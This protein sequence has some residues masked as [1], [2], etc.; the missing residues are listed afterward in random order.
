MTSHRAAANPAR[1]QPD[2]QLGPEEAGVRQNGRL[3]ITGDH[4]RPQ[5]GVLL[6]RFRPG[7][8]PRGAHRGEHDGEDGGRVV[9][10]GDFVF[11]PRPERVFTKEG[12]FPPAQ[13]VCIF[14][15]LLTQV[16]ILIDKVIDLKEVK[17]FFF[18]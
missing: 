13:K 9:G 1:H 10:G 15:F 4:P 2:V 7:G 17:G 11:G 6:L 16:I 5:H 12:G 3:L 14:M 8:I 18:V